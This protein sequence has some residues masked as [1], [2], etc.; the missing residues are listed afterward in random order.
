[1]MNFCC[2]DTNKK[3]KNLNVFKNNFIS[4]TSDLTLPTFIP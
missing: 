2:E 1:M 4:F 3:I